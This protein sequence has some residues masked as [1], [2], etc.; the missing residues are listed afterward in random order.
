MTQFQQIHDF[1]IWPTLEFL[2]LNSK[3]ARR[4]L[5]GTMAHESRGEYFD[6]VLHRKDRTL[7]PAIGLYQIEPATHDDIWENWLMF[8]DPIRHRMTDLFAREPGKH[9]Q[10]ATNVAYA[11]G[12]AR[13]VYYRQPEDL[14]HW[15]DEEGLAAYWKKYYNTEKGAGTISEWL[16]SFQLVRKV[17]LSQPKE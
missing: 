12:I 6:Q 14:P 1:V 15:E 10:L 9:E 13:L 4:L 5:L 8:R 11:T 17:D 2:E 3:E 16:L 7:G